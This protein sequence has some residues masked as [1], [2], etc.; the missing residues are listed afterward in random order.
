MAA[1]KTRRKPA[2]KESFAD[3][4][5][6]FAKTIIGAIIIVMFINGAAIASF[7]VPTPSMENT[8][9]TGDFLFVNKFL[10]GPTTPQVIPFVN[11]PLPYF[12]F[13]GIREPE[14]GDVIVFVYP[15]NRDE[16]EPDEF[17][18]YLKRC[19]ATQ[20][21]TLE[22]TD[23]TIYVNGV[24]YELPEHGKFF[25]RTERLASFPPSTEFTLDNYGPIAI[26]YE[27]MKVPLRTLKDFHKWSVLIQREGHE[28]SFGTDRSIKIDGKTAD[29]YTIERDYVF[30][31]GD[32]RDN[33]E[34]SRTWGF[35]PKENVVGTPIMVYWSWPVSDSRHGIQKSFLEE[36]PD[37]LANIKWH[38]IGTMIR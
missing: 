26:P 4:V 19:V 34:D 2:R 29:E 1:K 11:I 17:Q 36:L 23:K 15:G 8:V 3:Q 22:I 32:N 7:V 18:Y 35:I 27:G 16:I 24:K 10:Y 33:S 38:R 20:G 28:V 25:D 31:M 30:G 12:K 13:P 37:K 5:V 9:M 6:S 14:K 21:D